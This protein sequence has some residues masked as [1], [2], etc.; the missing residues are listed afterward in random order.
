MA[1]VNVF[2]KPVDE[3]SDDEIRLGLAAIGERLG[4]KPD[5]FA[6]EVLHGWA[7]RLAR[8]RDLRRLTSREADHMVAAIAGV[9]VEDDAG[10]VDD[11]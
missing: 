3:W 7:R 8:E 10:I 5:P 2:G 9:E 1:A 6:A 11:E 4:G